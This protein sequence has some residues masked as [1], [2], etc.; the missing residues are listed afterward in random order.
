ME[1][2]EPR[3][4]YETIFPK[5]L[6]GRKIA[7]TSGWNSVQI[8]GLNCRV[9]TVVNVGPSQLDL[10]VEGGENV[11]INSIVGEVED[12]KE[13]PC[14]AR[15]PFAFYK[16]WD[17]VEFTEELALIMKEL[18]ITTEHVV[19]KKWKVVNKFDFLIR[20]KF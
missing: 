4:G 18:G 11:Y 13:A 5:E 6:K 3:T 16:T 7:Y 20:S 14:I 10:T 17:A 19:S 9:G 8:E 1:K 15:V 2:Y 12:D